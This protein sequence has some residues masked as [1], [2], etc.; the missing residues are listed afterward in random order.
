MLARL[1][2]NHILHCLFIW[3][4][5]LMHD[6]ARKDPLTRGHS[7]VCAHPFHFYRILS[8]TQ[9]LSNHGRGET[10]KQVQHQ[11]THFRNRS[12]TWITNRAQ[13]WNLIEQSRAIDFKSRF[14]LS[15]RVHMGYI[16]GKVP[17]SFNR[18]ETQG[19]EWRNAMTEIRMFEG[20]SMCV[21][22]NHNDMYNEQRR[23]WMS[24]WHA[25]GGQW[26]IDQM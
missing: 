11:R 18:G 15:N 2:Y 6:I 8:I 9:S 26:R 25:L 14:K 1:W 7:H 20:L 13:P 24:R 3:W 23:Q 10:N 21:A 5:P 19:H 16:L 4:P 22:W 17:K 12:I